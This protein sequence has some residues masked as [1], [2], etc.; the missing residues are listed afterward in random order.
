[1]AGYRAA[2]KI[3]LGTVH[4]SFTADRF[5][6][7]PPDVWRCLFPSFRLSSYSSSLHG[8]CNFTHACTFFSLDCPSTKQETSYSLTRPNEVQ[9][10]V[11]LRRR[12][13]GGGNASSRRLAWT[14]GCDLTLVVLWKAVS[15]ILN[16][17]SEL[18]KVRS[19]PNQKPCLRRRNFLYIYLLVCFLLGWNRQFLKSIQWTKSTK[20]KT[21]KAWPYK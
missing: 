7:W 4:T 13:L 17:A 9:L 5:A 8:E 14:N 19:P 21:S 12:R 3:N 16:L 10:V 2:P 11:I 1:M 20:S 18:A 15:E 6:S